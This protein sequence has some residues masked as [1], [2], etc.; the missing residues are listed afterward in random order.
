MNTLKDSEI[1]EKIIGCAMRVHGEL[2][3]GFQEVIY[4]R[5]LDIEMKEH[6]L[7]VVRE[8]DMPIH[9]K[10]HAVGLRRVDFLVENRISVE[11]KALF[12][13]EDL[14]LVQAK[15][16]LEAYNIQTGLLINFGAP[17]LQFKRLFNNKYKS[18]NPAYPKH[19]E[20]PFHPASHPGSEINSPHPLSA[21][22]SLPV[23][24]AKENNCLRKADLY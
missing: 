22:S 2:G 1:T 11:L 10:G 19:P 9:Y 14:H 16:Y 20:H 23:S 12:E 13:L 8:F 18:K 17:R 7:N 21:I 6:G 24:A 15:N 4:Q 5:S 3:N